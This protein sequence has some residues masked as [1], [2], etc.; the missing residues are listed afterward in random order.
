MCQRLYTQEV[1]AR[2]HKREVAARRRSENYQRGFYK[3][4]NEIIM[5]IA[6]Y[7]RWDN[8]LCLRAAGS[9]FLWLCSPKDAPYAAILVYLDD[10]SWD[11]F[12]ASAITEPR[13][14]VGCGV[15]RL[16]CGYCRREGPVNLFYPQERL[17]SPY[18]RQC[19]FDMG[20][21]QAVD[22]E[23]GFDPNDNPGYL[24]CSECRRLCEL[25]SFTKWERIFPARKRRCKLHIQRRKIE[26]EH[27][28]VRHLPEL[29]TWRQK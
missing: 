29:G 20:F 27:I 8:A 9:R 6:E 3:L 25:S 18:L 2:K 22:A 19:V 14:Y 4:P 12:V 21:E 28:F 5:Q 17:K 15:R 11:E 7:L 23:P 1:S 16:H 26:T 24:L 10:L 13:Y